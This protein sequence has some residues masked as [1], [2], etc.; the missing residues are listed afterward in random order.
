MT[1]LLTLHRPLRLALATLLAFACTL[2][3][4]TLLRDDEHVPRPA[5]PTTFDGVVRPDAS[6]DAEI[7]RL[8]AAVRGGA[9]L[10]AQLAGA[11]LQKVR[12]TGDPSFYV[13]AD[14]VLTRALARGPEDAAELVEAA[15][16]AAGRHD[17]GGALAA[18]RARTLARAGFDRRAPGPGRRARRA[19]PLRRRP[20]SRSSG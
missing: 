11:Y 12:E 1:H 18:R 19:R 4:L 8:Q 20:S 6:T 9:P 13:R 2:A 5:V 3:V 7:A 10:E 17:F 14:G 16:L 15:T